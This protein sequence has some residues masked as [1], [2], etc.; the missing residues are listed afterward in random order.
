MAKLP[1][2][3]PVVPMAYFRDLGYREAGQQGS[4]LKMK[5]PGASR[6]LI[7]LPLVDRAL[8]RGSAPIFYR[9]G[10]A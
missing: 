1:P 2:V 9:R 6:S 5:K 7:I 8:N 4:H 3:R 10:E